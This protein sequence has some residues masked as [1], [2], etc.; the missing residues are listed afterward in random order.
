MERAELSVTAFYGSSKPIWSLLHLLSLLLI[1][2][3]SP[4][5]IS[6]RP[7]LQPRHSRSFQAGRHCWQTRWGW[8]GVGVNHA[9]WKA[10]SPPAGQLDLVS[11]VSNRG[12][13]KLEDKF[14][15][16]GGQRAPPGFMGWKRKGEWNYDIGKWRWRDERHHK[17]LSGNERRQNENICLYGGTQVWMS[18]YL[19]PDDWPQ[20]PFPHQ[21]LPD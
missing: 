9:F 10:A 18:D 20:L 6:P 19:S 11:S 16:G 8:A 4:K 12:G 15:R 7:R 3:K 13:E 17:T 5:Y 1:T 21:N 14:C 2:S